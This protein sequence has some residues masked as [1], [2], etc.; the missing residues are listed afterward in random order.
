GFYFEQSRPTSDVN[1][2]PVQ[3]DPSP[4]P[5]RAYQTPAPQSQ[6]IPTP[7]RRVKVPVEASEP[8]EPAAQK[9][10]APDP[11]VDVTWRE[12]TQELLQLFAGLS[13][14]ERAIL[15]IAVLS[16]G[17]DIYAARVRIMNTGNVPVTIS[18]DNI[19]IHFGAENTAAMTMDHP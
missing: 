15:G 11:R 7:S 6:P 16:T 18:P 8:L 2:K 14:Q 12:S 4:P 10:P 5:E 1:L 19:R 13:Q 9:S 17:M 3:A